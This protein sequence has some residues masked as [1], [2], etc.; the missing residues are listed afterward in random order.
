MQIDYSVVNTKL[1]KMQ[2]CFKELASSIIEVHLAKLEYYINNLPR[3]PKC[4]GIGHFGYKDFQIRETP[5][6]GAFIQCAT[7]GFEVSQPSIIIEQDFKLFKR[8]VNGDD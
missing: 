6:R 7:C 5:F 3:C 8:W 4:G 1:D 2:K